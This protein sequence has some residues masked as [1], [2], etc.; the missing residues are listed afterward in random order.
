MILWFSGTGNSQ[1]VAEQLGA[2]LK[3]DVVS[4]NQRM[5]DN[6]FH[7]VYSER[8]YVIV[9][10][11]YGLNLPRVVKNMLIRMPLNGAKDIYFVLTCSSS[12]CGAAGVL[13][14]LTAQLSMQ[15][16]GCGVLKMPENYIVMFN[17]PKE[18]I[19]REIIRQAIPHIHEIADT[20]QKNQMLTD[21]KTDGFRKLGSKLFE[22]TF[23]TLFVKD[24]KFHFDPRFCSKCGKCLRNC[25][26]QNISVTTEGNLVWNGRCTHC[27]A[28]ICGCANGAIEYGSHTKDKNRYHFPKNI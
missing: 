23:Y 3:D 12:V 28:C 6:D 4:M 24:R 7:A 18:E 27:M 19:A 10:P 9:S 17:P 8:P 22:D 20:I 15:Y 25:P 1:F 2:I 26:M 13:A 16:K 21:G 5:I 14:E 11:T